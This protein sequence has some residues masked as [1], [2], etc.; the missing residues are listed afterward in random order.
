MSKRARASWRRARLQHAHADAGGGGSAGCCASAARDAAHLRACARCERVSR[1][2]CMQPWSSARLDKLHS[3]PGDGPH[4]PRAAHAHEHESP[5]SRPPSR[6][7]AR[8]IP[9]GSWQGSQK[10]AAHLRPT[11]RGSPAGEGGC[12]R[13]VVEGRGR[14]ASS[15]LLHSLA[16]T[17]SSHTAPTNPQHSRTRSTP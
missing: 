4:K 10:E 11:P 15:P 9:P 6:F 1:R 13:K 12:R 3:H 16:H 8:R 17:P 5:A 14:E 2:Q 7:V